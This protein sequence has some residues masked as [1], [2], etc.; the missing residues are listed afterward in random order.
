M[1]LPDYQNKGVGRRLLA[2]IEK[3]FQ[4]KRFELFTGAK[5]EKNIALYE[6]CGFTL[7]KT[8]E[9]TQGLSFVYLEKSAV[10][11]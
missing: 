2:A 10:E 9:I 6:K 11:E 4:G 3:E 7:F 5:S 1:V 8:V